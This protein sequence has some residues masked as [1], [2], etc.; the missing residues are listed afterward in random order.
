MQPPII[1]DKNRH[2][3][4]IKS[5][6]NWPQRSHIDENDDFQEATSIENCQKK[7]KKS[8]LK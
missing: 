2:P 7:E 3:M 6:H 1:K 8:A 5:S 4:A